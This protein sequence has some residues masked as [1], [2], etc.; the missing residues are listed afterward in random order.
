MMGATFMK[1]G[2][3][4]ATSMMCMGEV[5]EFVITLR[6]LLRKSEDHV[7]GGREGIPLVD[8]AQAVG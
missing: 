6:L 4:A 2:R 5:F 7:P 1:L 8:H 3:A